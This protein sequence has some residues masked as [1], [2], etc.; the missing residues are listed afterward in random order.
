MLKFKRFEWKSLYLTKY[1]IGGQK[2]NYSCY[3]CAKS[4]DMGANLVR[5]ICMYL[6]ISILVKILFHINYTNFYY[7]VK[8]KFILFKKKN[9]DDFFTVLL[10]MTF[11]YI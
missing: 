11:A 2:Q 3:M 9:C 6:L 1:D 5:W 8:Q 4:K 10:K 7:M